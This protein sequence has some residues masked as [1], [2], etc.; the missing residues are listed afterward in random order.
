VTPPTYI[1]Y[2]NELLFVVKY[3]KAVFL[4]LTYNMKLVVVGS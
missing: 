2:V 4:G 1:R 3:Q